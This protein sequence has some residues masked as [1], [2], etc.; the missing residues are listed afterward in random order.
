MAQKYL[1]DEGGQLHKH[2]QISLCEAGASHQ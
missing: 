2:V 1:A